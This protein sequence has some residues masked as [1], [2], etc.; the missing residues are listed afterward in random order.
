MTHQPR[1]SVDT[2]PKAAAE[3]NSG[4]TKFFL[5]S[6][7][8]SPKMWSAL[9]LLWLAFVQVSIADTFTLGTITQAQG[10]IAGTDSV[11][12]A[13]DP[14]TAAWTATANASW[15]HLNAGSESGTGSA[16]VLYTFDPNSG[17]TRIGT[18]TI[19]GQTLTI[20]QGGSTFSAA[21]SLTT[22]LGTG[23]NNPTS[24]ALDGAGNVYI[25]DR[26]TSTIKRWIKATNSTNTLITAGLSLPQAIALDGAGNVYIAD[27]GNNAIKKWTATNSL[28]S[29]LVSNGLTNPTGVAVDT[30]GNV[31]IADRNNSA[32]KKWS[33]TDSNV[34][35]LVNSGLNNPTSVA[36]DAAGNVYIS[37]TFNGAIK[38]WTAANSNVTTLVSS[39]LNTPLGIAVDGAGNVYIANTSSHNIRKWTAATDLVTTI[40]GSGLL[41]PNGVAVDAAGSIYVAN[42]SGNSIRELPRA[43]VDTTTRFVASTSG[44]DMLPVALPTTANLL[45]PF[46]PTSNQPWLTIAGASNGTINVNFT[47]N[48]G[49]SR[50]A[51]LNVL[52]ITVPVMQAAP[53]LPDIE[54]QQPID[55][56]L[57]DAA[58]TNDFG[59]GL[60][61]VTNLTKTFVITNSGATNLT[62]LVITKDGT[63]AS[64][65]II[66]ALGNTNLAV[67]ASTTFTV[68]FAPA[69]VGSRT[70][71]IH[72][73]SNDP[74]E[75]PFDIA[76]TGTGIAA[77]YTLAAT[78]RLV[79]PTS[80]SD[81]V[82]LMASPG[83]A[84][85]TATATMPWLHISAAS[86]NGTGSTNIVFTFDANSG[87][88]RSGNLIIAGKIYTV[89]QAGVGYVSAG[90]ATSLA[91]VGPNLPWDLATD[92]AGNVYFANPDADTI[93]K[94]NLTNNTLSSLVSTGLDL[95]YG[96]A[97]DAAGNVYIAD[98]ANNSIRKWNS[99]NNT[100]TT[101]VSSGLSNP[102]DVALDAA[103][104]VYIADT[105]NNAIKKWTAT[106]NTVSTVVGVGLGLPFGIALDAAGNIYIADTYNSAV[107]KWTAASDTVST[108]VATG[109]SFPYGVTVDVAG[110]VY[111]ADTENSLLKKWTA[112]SN[113]VTTLIA[114]GISSPFG[115]EVDAAGNIFFSDS[116][117][118]AI[119]ALPRVFVSPTNKFVNYLAGNDVLPVI[120]PV[121]A[122][123]LAPFAPISTQP[124]LT[125]SGITNGVISFAFAANPGGIRSAD[126]IVFGQTNTITQAALPVP[127]IGVQQPIGSNLADGSASI[128][129][130]SVFAG[131]ANSIKTFT[132]TNSGGTNL[133]G[134]VI[135]KNGANPGDFSVSPLGS[136]NLTVNASTTF[137]VTFAPTAIGSRNAA[138]HIAS[139]DADENPFDIT[140]TGTGAAPIYSLNPISISVGQTAGTNNTAL[141]VT[142]NNATWAATAN[143]SWLHVSSANQNGTGSA[144]I[145]F[146]YDANPGAQRIG[147]LTIGGQTLTV[148][149]AALPFTA[150]LGFTNLTEG[151]IAGSNSVV[152]AITPVTSSAWTATAND[153]WLHLSAANQSGVGSTNVVYT[154][155]ANSNTTRTGTLTIAGQTLTV[156]QGG[157]GYT[158]VNTIASLVSAGLS[159]PHGV[160]VDNNGNVFIADT[161]NN[162][163]K[164]WTLTNN[165]VT[166][167]VSTGLS[168]PFGLGV[169]TAGNVLIA[170]T[171]NNALKKWS[172][173]TGNVTTLV[174]TGLNHPT[175]LAVDDAGNVY[176]A[177][178][179]NNAIKKWIAANNT[180]SNLV[181]TGLNLPNGVAVD[182]AGNVY[183]ADTYNNLIKK[184]TPA[185]NTVTTVVATGLNLP[186]GLAVDG[187]GNVYF[188]DRNN[189]ALK[190]WTA[191]SNSVTALVPT[192]LNLPNCVAVDGAGH[193]YMADT[194]NQIIK[195]L[196]RA[197]VDQTAR[198]IGNA[199]GT[200]SLSPV[201]PTS[202]NLLAP[203]AP[204][205][206]QPWLTINGNSAG[207]VD[208]TVTANS[209]AG[210]SANLTVLGRTVT[211][212][213][214]FIITAPLLSTARTPAGLVLTFAANPGQ[215]YQIQSAPAVTGPWTTNTVLTG[216]ISGIL[217]YTNAISPTGNRF[218]RTR[219][220]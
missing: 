208:F 164:K 83:N 74:D 109:L 26:N 218:F 102:S 97:V 192:G 94:W 195:E 92:V 7:G 87:A 5:S 76:L 125:I 206:N 159:L 154:F 146:T 80:G 57:T 196:P 70:A 197:F 148:T 16:N 48:A 214:T 84:S 58:T 176:L 67:N 49:I 149:Q 25:A 133:T 131:L 110:N 138:I 27:S 118:F 47:A 172:P 217:N 55:T 10:P 123:L 130:G 81:S 96:V 95:P 115:V 139:N 145:V 44:S 99:N 62:S 193:I 86:Q 119:K 43:F 3:Q 34:I 165:T 167:L 203:F 88:T 113:T 135:T 126:L 168:L 143:A 166:T 31:Y 1:K 151:P 78:N 13:V 105:Y 18:F 198:T 175:G 169:D 174:G 144:N 56:N 173:V 22:L 61:L 187:A 52:G 90:T 63:H 29:T 153:A 104:N 73:A 170:D 134:L 120:L 100:V 21:G 45:T 147:T 98:S 184:W 215:L 46:A 82:V 116:G 65:F 181:A 137:T 35:T 207:V 6:P 212:T 112:A 53:L 204:A 163:I 69:A 23:L 202:I 160:A 210:R 51:N 75:N 20:T 12:L 157:A 39:G 213:Q 36:V 161:Y 136:T 182:V 32:I 72:I 71:A 15:L 64:D 194:F 132:I 188:A 77:T 93:H 89:M 66:G 220:P 108:V 200:Y 141:T 152:L 140:L 106:N 79:G 50:T 180:V 121:N 122:N 60:I 129:Y 199:A 103:G 219:T 191:L 155:D 201:L 211:V 205:I 186:M 37:D 4:V 85:W 124:W 19:A 177:D 158:N 111:I 150:A 107:K 216:T 38:K 68:S 183:I 30:A 162:A 59:T 28:V 179:N 9:V 114:S 2:N 189:N 40:I 190:K 156:T 117:N 128:N 101:L 171:Y 142:P 185:N 178:Q 209:G 24:V 8:A 41:S 14:P 33:I 127:E 54:V 11:V 17:G 42:S 91:T